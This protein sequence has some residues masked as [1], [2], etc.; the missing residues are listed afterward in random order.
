MNK[1]QFINEINGLPTSIAASKRAKYEAALE[2]A[3][4]TIPQLLAALNLKITRGGSNS[5]TK[6]GV[7][8]IYLEPINSETHDSRHS[9]YTV[10]AVYEWE[11]K[12]AGF[13][14]PITA[15]R[16]ID[17]LQELERDIQNKTATV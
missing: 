12:S 13:F 14:K 16:M 2:H 3:T 7:S 15:N 8:R 5:S 6:H 11:T 9:N 10:A 4:N 17:F 1:Q